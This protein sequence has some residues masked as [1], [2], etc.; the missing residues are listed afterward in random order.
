MEYSTEYLDLIAA[1]ASHD[2]AVLQIQIANQPLGFDHGY[3]YTR[4]Q[5]RTRNQ[6]Y[7]CTNR[8]DDANHSAT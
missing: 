6:A 4:N 3:F 8:F 7:A 2:E 5:D 1:G